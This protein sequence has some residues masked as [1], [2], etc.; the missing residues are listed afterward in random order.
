MTTRNTFLLVCALVLSSCLA[1]DLVLLSD[2]EGA[3]CIDG[4]PGGFY[5]V[6]GDAGS[7]DFIIFMNGG[8]VCET[9]SDCY[10]RSLTTL[11]SSK[12]WPRTVANAGTASGFLSNSSHFASWNKAV[13][14]YCDGGRY[15]SNADKPISYNNV[16]LYFRGV[17]IMT[18]VV[19][20]LTANY[21][22]KN[23]GRVILSGCSAGG[24]GTYYLLD[25]IRSIIPKNVDVR[26]MADAGWFLDTVSVYGTPSSYTAEL[27]GAFAMWNSSNLPIF[28]KCMATFDTADQWKCLFAANLYPFQETPLFILQSQIDTMQLGSLY[29]FPC[30]NN[31]PSCNSTEIQWL[32]KWTSQFQTSI[33]PAIKNPRDGIFMDE[34]PT[35]CQSSSNWMTTEISGKTPEIAFYNWYFNGTSAKYYDTCTYPCN[36]SC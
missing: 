20:E 32:E 29:L 12:Q 10:A 18:A 27:P 36:K 15:S 2:Y 17:T 25:Y 16:D 19:E 5:F 35:H 13:V 9:P 22:M 31:F 34:C 11:G 14:Q 4:S 3:V 6:P 8:G 24:E 1:A 7:T 21:G 23:A 30:V 33:M 28:Q 26:G